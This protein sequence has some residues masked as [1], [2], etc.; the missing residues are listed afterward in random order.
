MGTPAL[1]RL[2]TLVRESIQN[3]LDA[4]DGE[5][6]PRVL[7]RM[8]LTPEQMEVLD[9]E[10]LARLP[11]DTSSH[12]AIANSLARPGLRVLELCDF[13]LGASPG[14]RVPMHP[15]MSAVSATSSIFCAMLA[16]PGRPSRWGNVW[17]RQEFAVRDEQLFDHHCG[18]S[19]LQLGGSRYEGSWRAISVRHMTHKRTTAA[20]TVSPDGTGGAFPTAPI[21]SSRQRERWHAPSLDNLDFPHAARN[22]PGRRFS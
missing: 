13:V 2:P 5:S 21:R 12:E 4:S 14:P 22:R 15:S 3:V 11:G 20:G 17:L 18:F 10:V 7:I 6:G 19:D 1:G 8:T 9:R 16:L